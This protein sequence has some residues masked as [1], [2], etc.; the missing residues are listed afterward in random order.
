M[1]IGDK[2]RHLHGTEEGVVTR[3]LGKEQVEVEIEEGFRIPFAARDLVVVVAMEAAVF[4]EDERIEATKPKRRRKGE[5]KTQST[6]EKAQPKKEEYAAQ[7]LYLAFTHRNDHELELFLI[8]NT[9]MELLFSLGEEQDRNYNG[10]ASGTISP[11]DYLKVHEMNLHKFERWPALVIQ[12]IRF[13][14]GLQ[15]LLKPLERKL[16]WKASSFHKHKKDAPIINKESYLFQIDVEIKEVDVAKIKE[17]M[18]SRRV[19]ST[20]PNILATISKDASKQA[21]R[22]VDLHIEAL[23]PEYAHIKKSAILDI[24]LKR[25]E[26]SL[27]QAIL[28]NVD[29]ITFIHG[30]GAGVLRGQ[31]HAA[32]GKHPHVKHFQDARKEKFGYGATLVKLK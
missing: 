6:P 22:E 8:N 9:D 10:I 11:K 12:A 29:E 18:E 27:D 17:A 1:N 26:D 16:K 31:I 4:R 30:V 23:V 28:A 2:V 25:F 5:T 21:S 24:Q 19:I 20:N 13:K 7:G 15:A 3:F 32:L 14:R